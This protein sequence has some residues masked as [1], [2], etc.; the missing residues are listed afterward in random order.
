[1]ELDQSVVS[2]EIIGS[3]EMNVINN[4]IGVCETVLYHSERDT[5]MHGEITEECDDVKKIWDNCC[6]F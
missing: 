4:I 2:S 3:T 1:M 6:H 5:P